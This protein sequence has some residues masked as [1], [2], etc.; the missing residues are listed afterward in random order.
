[1]R[2]TVLGSGN[3]GTAAAFDWASHDHEVAL[4]DFP[5][6][7]S[8]VA[9]IASAGAIEGRV[10]F[11]G[12]AP[13]RYAGHDLDAALAGT[14]L[15][16]VVAPAYAHE[17]LGKALRDRVPADAMICV[18]PSACNGAII[19]KQ[20]LGLDLSDDSVV[21]G[22]THTLPYGCRL[23]APGV[24]RVTTRLADG[25]FA[26]AL[27]SRHTDALIERLRLVW[28]F[29]EPAANV[30]QTTLQN[31]NPVLHPAIMLLNAA[32][33]EDTGGDF[34]FYT[35]GVTAGTAR[36]IEEIDSERLQLGRALGL[37]LIGDP[38]L[39]VRQGYLSEATYLHGYNH[40]VGFAG[41]R[42]PSTLDFRY[43]TEDVPYGMVFTS[44]L[45]R[46]VGVPTPAIDG[47]IA[48]ASAMLGVD[49]RAQG[50]RLPA[51]LGLGH[52]TSADHTLD[53]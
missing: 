52:V 10:R 24:I 43:L 35:Q 7:P 9:A 36:L 50:K 26:A 13:V 44:E 45:A 42:A 20:A 40:G 47:V 11:E 49:F 29:V 1:M 14:Q 17:A 48:V 46:Q 32:R 18:L 25:M 8:N 53:F 33:I 16:L 3:G 19:V 22:E 5:E 30:L 37:Q 6:F 38:D 21:I 39:G 28:P 51:Q 41:S 12:I 2:V 15:I 23:V 31:A 27:P 4:W 34:L